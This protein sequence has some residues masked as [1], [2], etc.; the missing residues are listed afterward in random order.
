ME[1][2]TGNGKDMPHLRFALDRRDPSNPF[3]DPPDAGLESPPASHPLISVPE[4]LYSPLVRVD[5]SSAEYLSV[6]PPQG[7][8]ERFRS[9]GEPSNLSSVITSWGSDVVPSANPSFQAGSVGGSRVSL[10]PGNHDEE[11]NTQTVGHLFAIVPNE[12]LIVFPHDVEPD[13]AMHHPD[14]EDNK[15][16]CR[17]FTTRGLANIGALVLLIG[18]LFALFI[19]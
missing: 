2:I 6:P 5:T 12:D 11:I 14:P 7:Y 10:Y 4:P 3:K 18:G 1:E 16:D 9:N 19:G 15:R 8:F 17:I 13:D